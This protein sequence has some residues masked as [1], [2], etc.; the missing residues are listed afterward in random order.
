MI[1]CIYYCMVDSTV[2][3]IYRVKGGRHLVNIRK[4]FVT[5]SQFPFEVGESLILRIEKDHVT[6]KKANEGDE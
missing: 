1:K 6:M 5:D 4:D 2:A 3:K